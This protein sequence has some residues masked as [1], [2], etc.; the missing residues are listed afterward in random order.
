MD[1]RAA[2]KLHARITC[3]LY[4]AD[5]LIYAIYTDTMISLQYIYLNIYEFILISLVN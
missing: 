1:K 3:G 2:S 5:G 4:K